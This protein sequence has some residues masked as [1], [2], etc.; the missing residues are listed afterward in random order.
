M[1][2]QLSL[3]EGDAQKGLTDAQAREA[4]Q[5]AAPTATNP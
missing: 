5:E 3:L 2:E 4:Q 1:L